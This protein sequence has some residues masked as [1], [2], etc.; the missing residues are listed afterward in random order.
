MAER[1]VPSTW[2]RERIEIDALFRAT[3]EMNTFDGVP[4]TRLAGIS[5]AVLEKDDIGYENVKSNMWDE[6]EGGPFLKSNPIHMEMAREQVPAALTIRASKDPARPVYLS[7]DH[8]ERHGGGPNYDEVNAVLVHE[9]HHAAS[10]GFVDG[11]LKFFDDHDNSHLLDEAV[12][13]YFAKKVWD[14]RY[15]DKADDYLLYST[16]F[17][18]RRARTGWYGEAARRLRDLVG[19]RDLVAAYFRADDGALRRMRAKSAEIERLIEAAR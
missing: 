16:Y 3:V 15:P 12:T 10:R 17:K 5:F 18:D 8:F 2:S 11:D 9:A 1:Q 19:E 7:K 6:S 13:E 14:A 4:P